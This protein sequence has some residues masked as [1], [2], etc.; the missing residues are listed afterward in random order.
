MPVSDE[1]KRE[2]RKALESAGFRQLGDPDELAREYA[3]QIWKQGAD[4]P[5]EDVV[6]DAWLAGWKAATKQP[7]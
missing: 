6:R 4:H 5:S 1:F 3:A 2:F 7:R